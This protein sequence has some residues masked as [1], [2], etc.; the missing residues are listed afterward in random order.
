MQCC[1]EVQGSTIAMLQAVTQGS[2]LTW[3]Y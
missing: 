1:F 2:L 3:E